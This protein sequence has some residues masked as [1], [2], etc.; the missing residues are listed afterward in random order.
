MMP[1]PNWADLNF[2]T[3]LESNTSPLASFKST[4]F[5]QTLNIDEQ[6]NVL[7]DRISEGLVTL[8]TDKLSEAEKQELLGNLAPKQLGSGD[9]GGIVNLIYGHIQSAN[10]VS[11]AGGTGWRIDANGN[12][13]ASTGTFRGTVTA[14]SGTI[15]G[16][17]INSTSIYTGTEDF[18]GYTTNAGDITIYSNGTDSSIHAKNFYIDTSGNLFANSVTLS[19]A[20]TT[21]AGSSIVSDYLSGII[22][23]A[24]LNVSNRGWT[25][26]SVFSVTDADTVAWGAGTFT[27]ADGT[28]YSIA[29]AN[30]GNMTLKTY[31]YLDTAVSTTAYQ[32]T[33]TSTTAVGVGKVLIAIAQNAVA[34]A[35]FQVLS[36]QGGHN[37]DA[38][39]IV[40][41]SITGNE[42]AASTITAGKMSVT[43]L[44][45]IAVDIGS[46]T[47]GSISVVNGA[48]TIGFTPSGVNAIFSGP[49]G[50][51]SFKVTP[52]GAL[53]ATNATITGSITATS[54]TIGG[55]TIGATTLTG[56]GVTLDSAGGITISAGGTDY[57]VVDNTGLQALRTKG[58]NTAII[59]L[60]T[61]G[62]LQLSGQDNALNA[63]SI[64]L[65]AT[66]AISASATLLSIN[67]SVASGTNNNIEF[68]MTSANA[69]GNNVSISYNGTSS[70]NA[71]G[72]PLTIT[73]GANTNDSV[74]NLTQ[75]GTGSHISLNSLGSNPTTGLTAGDLVVVS[76]IL[77]EYNGSYWNKVAGDEIFGDGSD[78]N[79][80]ISVDTNLSADMYYNNLTVNTGKFI[81]TSGYRIFVK[82]TLTVNSGGII[83]RD[84]NNGGAGG[85]GANGVVNG[86][87]D[88]GVGGAG[89]TA[90][91]AG[92][93]LAAGT[94]LGAIAGA[95]GGAGGNG[96]ER[97]ESGAGIDGSNGLA[98]SNGSNISNSAGVNGQA[99]RVGATGGSASFASGGSGGA[100]GSTGTATASTYKPRNIRT[101]LEMFDWS[102]T[103]P[104]QITSSASSGGSGGSGGGGA[105]AGSNPND[106]GV[107]GG[108][109]GGGG[110]G[111]QGGIV[112]I[113]AK[114]IDNQGTI[115]ANG[116][117][118]GNGGNGGN[119][120]YNGNANGGGGGGGSAGHG[121]QGGVIIYIYNTLTGNT[122]VATGGAGGTAGSVG[123]GINGGGNGSAGDNGLSGN[124]GTVISIQV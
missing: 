93:L 100:A 34:E 50:T 19:G 116:G 33:T 40:A 69:S 115:S 47:A 113:A 94:L 70:N 9:I 48:N 86:V 26:T 72:F 49:T 7:T 122:P 88:S 109:G 61:T 16:W 82:N 5:Y 74:L 24:N 102:G 79:V 76:N 68:L 65:L 117:T 1:L 14:T 55:W 6:G 29:G 84:G 66:Q 31:I 114:T 120:A 41:G 25:Q 95:A 83:K 37:I 59:E 27:S 18:S 108:G 71:T 35:T 64:A 36:G 44:S 121:G 21:G 123:T 91:A 38:A 3:F 78:G 4:Q 43:Q 32:I 75:S 90:G 112:F 124:A 28:A 11:G 101:A 81:N 107:G 46:I 104:T 53:T 73:S 13:E 77:K 67:K 119:A 89:G 80:T 62:L 103:T 111:S 63:C 17:T 12:L 56:G 85:N 51:P 98:G 106:E 97:F 8:K 45:A 42:I 87:P 118:G 39:N 20:I 15:G 58:G 96:T 60:E 99:G 30:T 92:A 10:F 52:A 110:S 22:A 2:N 57:L 23:Q 54:G 105:Y